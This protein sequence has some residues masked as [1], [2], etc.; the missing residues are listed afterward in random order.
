MLQ[1]SIVSGPFSGCIEDLGLQGS[2]P[3]VDFLSIQIT[4]YSASAIIG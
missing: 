1:Q 2:A 4:G 3:L